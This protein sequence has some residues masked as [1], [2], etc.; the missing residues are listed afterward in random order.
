MDQ[1]VAGIAAAIGL[2]A[3][4]VGT[5]VGSKVSVTLLQRAHER[6]EDAVWKAINGSQSKVASVSER[7][8]AVEAVCEMK[9]KEGVC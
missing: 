7:L 4:A 3:G 5:V 8:A 9:K 1:T 6:F 2:I